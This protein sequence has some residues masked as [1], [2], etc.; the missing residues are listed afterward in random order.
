VKGQVINLGSGRDISVGTIADIILSKLK[1]SRALITYMGDR[2][3]QI[4]RHIASTEKAEKLIGWRA[5]TS[6][7][8]GID[9]TIK[10][11]CEFPDWWKKLLWMRKV[12]I[13]MADGRIEYH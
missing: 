2:P 11:Y 8:E 12:P 1:K 4:K 5:K 13:K 3:G 6:F 9:R 10:W 7:E